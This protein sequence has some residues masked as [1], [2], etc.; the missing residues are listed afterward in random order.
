M[1]ELVKTRY[2]INNKTDAEGY[3]HLDW[4]EITHAPLND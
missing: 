3:L 4:H 2:L 1:M